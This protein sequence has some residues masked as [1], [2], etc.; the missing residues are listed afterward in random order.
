MDSTLPLSQSIQITQPILPSSPNKLPVKRKATDDPF[1]G[2][3]AG[4]ANGGV[5]EMGSDPPFKFHRIWTEPDEI[6]FLQGLLDGSSEN[7]FF[8]RD[9][10]VFYTRF[11]NTMSQPYTKSQLS[12]KLRR[13]RKKFR[14]IS[15]RLSK[16]LDRSL[17]SPHDRA[18]YDLSKQ[19]WHP[20]FS[21]TSPFNAEKSKKSN[22][23]GVKVSFLPNIY[24]PNRYGIVPYQDENGS[25]CNGVSVNEEVE[26]G[27]EDK[28]N[29]GNV[30]FD[31]EDGKLSEV[32]VEL[33]TG[34][35]G[36][37]RV[38]FSR[39]NGPVPVGIEFG[40]GDTAA[41]VVMDVFDECLKDF[42][43]GERSNLG[44]VMKETSS[45]E[46][47]ER[48]KEQRVAELKVLARRMRLVLEHSLQSL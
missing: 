15:S 24:D 25:N 22:L 41:K 38:E 10:N 11:S 23:V 37:E 7:L 3:G 13:L 2:A 39:V 18:L 9:L 30:E 48:W 1:T 33:D 26:Q 35:I 42:R 43:N 5:G 44:A 31:D 19:L 6:R 46:F 32:N 8:P 29:D 12:E 21:D 14:V 34:E 20:D 36:D 40:V 16:G 28:E 4:D 45:N 47:E 17:L 27:E